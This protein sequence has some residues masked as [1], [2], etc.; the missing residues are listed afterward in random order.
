MPL[1]FLVRQILMLLVL[2]GTSHT[3]ALAHDVAAD[4]RLYGFVKPQGKTLEILLRV[5]MGSLNDLDYPRRKEQFLQIS[6]ADEAL[7]GAAK[8][9]I[10]DLLDVYENGVELPKPTVTHV[11]V[12]LPSDQSFRSYAQA[13]AHLDT[14][15]LD[16]GMDLIWGQ[17]MLDVR[18]EYPIES[19]TSDFSIRA[20]VD[21]YAH[22]V[23]TAIR[24]LPP[25]GAERA[26]ELSMD[27]G[28]VHL[29]PRWHQAALRFVTQGFW[30]ILDGIDHLLFLGCLVIPFRRL[31]PLVAI[32]T[33]FTVAHS[34]T[35]I[36]SAYG[37]VPDGLWFPPLIE[38]LIA[39]TI[40]Y[41]ALENIVGSNVMRRWIV[42]FCFGLI[43]GFGFSFA[44]R[45]QLQFAGDH[46]VTSL[47]AFNLGV[48]L[49]QLAVLLVLVPA[50]VL[51]FK[52]AWAERVGVI[53]LSAF[54]AHTGWHWLL[55]R[56]EALLKF[57][58]PVIDLQ[59][60]ASAMR[61]ALAA[62][63]LA[64]LIWLVHGTMKRWLQTET[65]KDLAE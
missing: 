36:A 53:I 14:P 32:V 13:R 10:T 34:I 47:L 6:E 18:L 5:P 52:Y 58:F 44:L 55:E 22:K 42:T 39:T 17:Q 7:R 56:G 23:S 59:F 43:H 27:P 9:Y 12:S 45:E 40:V 54:V 25:S 46:L 16:D 29:D 28:L 50:L 49:G 38:T 35:L 64:A 11:L 2:W 1:R 21:R 65:V 30:H 24:F 57:P 63:V 33:A 19:D 51:L 15:K 41:M 61:G 62:L 4:A 48:E 3:A 20:R 37:F 60:I 26:Y 8:V 31:R